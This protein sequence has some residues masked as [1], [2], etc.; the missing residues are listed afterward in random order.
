MAGST[1]KFTDRKLPKG[2]ADQ[3]YAD[4]LVQARP[5]A[6]Y[7]RRQS[8]DLRQAFMGSIR[9]SM[10]NGESTQ[11]AVT[12]VVGGT[13]AGVQVPGIMNVKRNQAEA[14]V[15][16]QIAA[17]VNSARVHAL[18][19]MPDLVKGYQQVSTLDNR[20]SDICMAYS[21]ATWDI[22]FRPLE[23]ST[24]PWNG[25]PPRHV[26]CRSTVVP[27]LKSYEELGIPVDKLSPTTRAS[28]DGQVPG[29]IT[30][31]EWLRK[32]GVATQNEMLGPARAKLWR[33]GKITLSQLVDMKGNPLTLE[34]LEQLIDRGALPVPPK[35]VPKRRP[36]RPKPKPKPPAPPPPAPEKLMDIATGGT[37]L[38]A[39]K[40]WHK[41][42]WT[43]APAW[44]RDKLARIGSLKVVRKITKKSAYYTPAEHG[45]NMAGYAAKPRTRGIAV[46]RH[47]YGHF[48]DNM[49]HPANVAHG[50]RTRGIWKWLSREGKLNAAHQIDTRRFTMDVDARRLARKKYLDEWQPL[51]KLN[52]AGL[53]KELEKLPGG[54]TWDDFLDLGAYVYNKP[55][56]AL[57]LN[58]RY[59]IQQKAKDTI[60]MI[61][62]GNYGE[63]LDKMQ[64]WWQWPEDEIGTL[65]DYFGALT[66]ESIGSG[67]GLAYYAKT[68][69]QST[70]AFANSMVFIGDQE[71]ASGRFFTRLIRSMGSV[72]LDT[73][74]ET[75]RNFDT[76]PFAP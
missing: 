46:W 58:E 41:T 13:I 29:D 1:I 57:S 20:T 25:G 68:N 51:H 6:D 7:W 30:F 10:Q 56:S 49:I 27:I 32:K 61:R 22:D 18:S 39:A 74:E 67:H 34:Q 53:A 75:V 38:K 37:D 3:L 47:E 69:Y 8:V 5:L 71:N 9:T 35:P 15:R 28:M 63:M 52:E 42:S 14:L 44:L 48:I 60:A 76:T 16:T 55:V 64:T 73:V 23:P 2:V 45:I 11:Q 12:R 70:E 4:K 36:A 31:D 62:S 72:F 19:N 26:N 59:L 17:S 21:G 33:D 40:P 54:L 43:G 24:L 50:G 66:T 65:Q